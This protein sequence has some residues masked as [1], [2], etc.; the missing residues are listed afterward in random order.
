MTEAELFKVAKAANSF[1]NIIP[2]TSLKTAADVETARA[3]FISVALTVDEFKE[4]YPG[5]DVEHIYF[6]N[7]Y[8]GS[9]YYWDPESMVVFPLQIVNGDYLSIN[10]TPLKQNIDKLVREVRESIEHNDYSFIETTL[11]D[12][13]RVEY[14]KMLVDKDLP[15]IYELFTDIYPMCDFGCSLFSVQDME[16]LFARKT[17][18]QKKRTFSML[19][20]LPPVFTVYRGCGSESAPL[21]NAYSWSLSSAV[22]VFFATRLTTNNSCIY[23]AKVKKEDI[24][25]YFADRNEQEC[26]ILP[27]KLFDIQKTDFYD[28]GWMNQKTE[29]ID[30]FWGYCGE[31]EYDK[32]GFET[33]SEI[34]GKEHSMRVLLFSLFL[35]DLYDLEQED[36]WILVDAA[37]YHDIGRRD[38]SEDSEHGARSAEKYVQG[39]MNRNPIV[40]FLMKYHCKPD[41]EGY[42]AI[43][44]DEKLSAEKERVVGLFKIFKDADALDRVRL[45]KF[46]LDFTQLRTD[47]AKKLPLIARIVKDTL[48]IEDEDDVEEDDE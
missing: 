34:H 29:I 45:G 25:E 33:E 8:S 35:A 23:T 36:E 28:I 21:E 9:A 1:S 26:L 20:H 17:D 15:N 31:A 32:A 5:V 47:E 14:L 44:S 19:E 38:D 12:R 24:F 43:D 16:K 6:G 10:N 27:D 48:K 30:A 22:A 40:L 13:M 37:T 4:K 11:N 7:F 3:K 41:A 42:A 39:I 2:L 18:E 46:E